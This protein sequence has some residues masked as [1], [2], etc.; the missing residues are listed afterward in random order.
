VLAP[1]R[2]EPVG[3]AID[4]MGPVGYAIDPMGD[5]GYAIDRPEPVGYAIDP[6]VGRSVTEAGGATRAF[7][8]A[9][10]FCSV[11]M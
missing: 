4:P 2:P 11:M 3:Y 9:W 8:I 10:T 6:M 5:V 7:L 1:N